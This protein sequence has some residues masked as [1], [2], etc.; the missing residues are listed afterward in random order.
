MGSWKINPLEEER[1]LFQY[2]YQI[3]IIVDLW[4]TDRF[5]KVDG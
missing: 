1:K 4:V 2:N 5:P 3:K